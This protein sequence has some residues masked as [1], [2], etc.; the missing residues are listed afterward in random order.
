MLPIIINPLKH[1]IKGKS[2]QSRCATNYL[3]VS[4]NEPDKP[5]EEIQHLNKT[6]IELKLYCG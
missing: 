2:C 1:M 5:E 4:I 6:I 3:K